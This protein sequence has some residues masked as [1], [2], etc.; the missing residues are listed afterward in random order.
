MTQSP[1]DSG[2]RKLVLGAAAAGALATIGYFGVTHRHGRG[3]LSKRAA[4]F[5]NRLR[6]PGASHLLGEASEAADAST[7]APIRLQSGILQQPLLDGSASDVWA[8]LHRNAAGAVQLNPTLFA[9][10]G[11]RIRVELENRLGDDTT[12]HWHG[13]SVD[14]AND[15]SGLHPVRHGER[16]LYD[17][18]VRNRAGLYW[19]HAHPH[20]QTGLQVHKGLAGLVV[21][22]DDEE[23]ALQKTLGLTWGVDD[24]ALSIS[25]KQFGLRNKIVHE[26]AAD[27]WI[28]NKVLINWTPD[29]VFEARRGWL[30]L[31][32]ANTSNARLYRIA[33]VDDHERSRAFHLIGTDAGLLPRPYRM[34]AVF[35][36]PGQ[37]L[38][39]L[40]DLRDAA[41]GDL[42]MMR[43]IAYEPMENDAGVGVPEDPAMEH[44]G[45][46]PMGEG[47]DLMLIRVTDGQNPA[48]G[49]LPEKLSTHDTG[50]REDAARRAFRLWLQDS[51]RWMINHWN[52]HLAHG[53]DV[54]EVKRGSVERWEITNDMRSMPHPMHLHGFQFIVTGRR[55]S[56][57]QI[58]AQVIDARGR[59]PQDMGLLDTVLVW[60]GETVSIQIDFAQP[61]RGRQRY[62]FHCHNLEHEDQGMMVAFAVVD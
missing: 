44:P 30:R 32:L 55:N 42:M 41:P 18:E 19:Y 60:P 34:E 49:N 26:I 13:F 62:M 28:G 48:S 38:D 5:R 36:A 4:D 15:G 17:F 10:S 43:S 1:P 27:D 57:A 7:S 53:E 6:I 25:D 39:L 8:Y 21:V 46:V 16:Y 11:G 61:Y 9:R 58:G 52:F 14:E 45:A 51:G 40:L 31:R 3:M 29:P 37:R 59:T 54:F 56:P 12:I 20:G 22:E 33:F 2:R 47:M 23:L 50:I 24:I 35:L